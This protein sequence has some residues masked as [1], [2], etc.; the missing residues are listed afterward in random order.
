MMVCATGASL[1]RNLDGAQFAQLKTIAAGRIWEFRGDDAARHDDVARVQTASRAC[2]MIGE[3][4]HGVEGMVQNVAAL[5]A[6]DLR[7][8]HGRAPLDLSEIGPVALKVAEHDP[9]VPGIV[10][11]ERQSFEVAVISVAVV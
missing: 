11:D 3:P 7:A 4:G 5:A 8:V 10:R 1:D 6:T 9:G 2:E